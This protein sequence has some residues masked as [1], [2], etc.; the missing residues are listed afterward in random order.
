MAGL[1]SLDPPELTDVRVQSQA[2]D[3]ASVSL[4]SPTPAR[5]LTH[6]PPVLYGCVG[7]H[8]DPSH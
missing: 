5:N 6:G 1:V 2:S 7:D 3:H 4:T 8:V